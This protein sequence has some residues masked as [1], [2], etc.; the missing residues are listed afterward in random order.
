MPIY[1][2][3]MLSIYILFKDILKVQYYSFILLDFI[4][5]VAATLGLTPI[6]YN[7]QLC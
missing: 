2:V 1:I 7:S 5:F 6:L 3:A 4:L